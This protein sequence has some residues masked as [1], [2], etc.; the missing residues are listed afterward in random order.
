MKITEGKIFE[1]KPAEKVLD[2]LKGRTLRK[3]EISQGYRV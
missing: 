2:F 1:M 3:L